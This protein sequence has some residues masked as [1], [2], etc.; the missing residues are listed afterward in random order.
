MCECV[1]ESMW[2]HLSGRVCGLNV[3]IKYAYMNRPF[4]SDGVTCVE[5]GQITFITRGLIS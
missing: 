1:C 4:I 5:N 2:L 3:H